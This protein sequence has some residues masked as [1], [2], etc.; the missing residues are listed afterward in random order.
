MSEIKK[1]K[2][3]AAG[4]LSQGFTEDPPV[5]KTRIFRKGDI[6]RVLWTSGIVRDSTA[7]TGSAKISEEESAM[8]Q[9]MGAAVLYAP[10]E[11]EQEAA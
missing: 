11:P 10:D 6:L 4:L 7:P 3:I 5:K 8:W 9:A 2:L 1:D